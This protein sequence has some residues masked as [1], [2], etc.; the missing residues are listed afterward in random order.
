MPALLILAVISWLFGSGKSRPKD[1]GPPLFT[2]LEA[3]PGR[4]WGALFCSIMAHTCCVIL[5]FVISD[6]F[7]GPD[8]D[9]L[10]RQLSRHALVIRLPEHIYLAPAAGP[11]FPST[12][13]LKQ[14]PHVV[15][16]RKDLGKYTA[17]GAETK[18]IAPPSTPLADTQHSLFSMVT[19]PPEPPQAEP[20]RFE[21][22]DLAV[23]EMS[24]QTV[25]Q[26][27]LPPNLPPQIQKQ[28]P[29]LIFWDS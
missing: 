8:D 20:R 9:F 22:P 24:T 26:A 2:A 1:D 17:G 3:R 19:P 16:R 15:V 14:A 23:R 6:L 28:L 10:P 5:L 11:S 29:Q 7:S 18:L 25:L 21:L 27:E 12:A 13:R 4:P